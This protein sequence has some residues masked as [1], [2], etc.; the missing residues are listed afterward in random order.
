MD[1]SKEKHFNMALQI[2]N[3]KKALNGFEKLVEQTATQ[4]RDER[5]GLFIHKEGKISDDTIVQLG[6]LV[7]SEKCFK[8]SERSIR[9]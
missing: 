7:R 2:S 9:A 4:K 1:I 5:A 8:P 3:F 6:L